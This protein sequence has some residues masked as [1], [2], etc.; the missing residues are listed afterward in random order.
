MFRLALRQTEGLIGSLLRLLGLD[1][2]HSRPFD[3]EP[4]GRDVAGA[5]ATALANRA[6][7]FAGGQHGLQAVRP[8]E[9]LVGKHGTRTRRSWRKLHIGV[10]AAIGEIVTAELDHAMMSMTARRSV[11]LLDRV[12]GRWL[13]SPAMG[14]TIGTTS[15]VQLPSVSR[16]GSHCAATFECGG[17]VAVDT[18]PTQRDEHLR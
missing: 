5:H 11:R 9:W 8:G 17:E 12:A 10:D 2:A 14:R 1:L 4:T 7:A 18:A 13:R 3:P 6:G 15:T 16:C